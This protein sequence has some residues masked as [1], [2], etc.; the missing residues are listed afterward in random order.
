[1][2]LGGFPCPNLSAP[3]PFFLTPAATPCGSP[4]TGGRTTF[5][6]ISSLSAMTTLPSLSMMKPKSMTNNNTDT[7]ERS[8]AR[9][10][11]KRLAEY[12]LKP[13]FEFAFG[14]WGAETIEWRLD[15]ESI[16]V[17]V[18]QVPNSSGRY[19]PAC[20]VAI[21]EHLLNALVKSFPSQAAKDDVDM[22][23]LLSFAPLPAGVVESIR[24]LTEKLE[25]GK[26]LLEFLNDCVFFSTSA[27]GERYSRIWQGVHDGATDPNDRE[28]SARR[29]KAEML[30]IQSGSP[31][32]VSITDLVSN[33]TID[34]SVHAQDTMVEPMSPNGSTSSLAPGD[35]EATTDDEDEATTPDMDQSLVLE[36]KPDGKQRFGET[37]SRS[38]SDS[39]SV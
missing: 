9:A 16:V 2:V 8:R 24:G 27:T 14:T 36:V 29:M 34:D 18:E 35:T 5:G 19:T 15:G 20:I 3:T 33:L 31:E 30:L 39:L 4:G 7:S 13:R 17:L 28:R 6:S 21:V 10:E 1:M 11:R 22:P 32:I 25:L 38:L 26:D 23:S 12:S 37:R